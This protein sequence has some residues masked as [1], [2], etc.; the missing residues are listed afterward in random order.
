MKELG[1]SFQLTLDRTR[2]PWYG[3]DATAAQGAVH[4]ALNAR[5]PDKD[6][7]KQAIKVPKAAKPKKAMLDQVHLQAARCRKEFRGQ[8]RG[9]FPLAWKHCHHALQR[10]VKN[11]KTTEMGKRIGKFHLGK[12]DFNQ[13]HTIHHGASKKRKLTQ[14]LKQGASNAP[15]GD[16]PTDAKA[17]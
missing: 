17:A 5:E 15:K 16:T 7:W 10:E 13:I 9:G 11:V 12:Q 2:L 6:R 14:A 1:P 4:S 3:S 8:G